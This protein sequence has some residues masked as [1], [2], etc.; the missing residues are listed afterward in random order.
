MMSSHTASTEYPPMVDYADDRTLRGIPE[1]F[2]AELAEFSA[3]HAP[4]RFTVCLIEDDQ[5][6]AVIVGWGMALID[7][8]LV[9]LPELEESDHPRYT[10]RT[11]PSIERMR[12]RLCRSENV[13]LVWIDP[14]PAECHAW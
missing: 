5:Q 4:S 7:C 14:E 1:E 2:A 3:E 11:F 9:Y 12:R 8:V 10:I 6:D 13:R